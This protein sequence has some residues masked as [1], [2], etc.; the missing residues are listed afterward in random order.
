MN[1]YW[2]ACQFKYLIEDAPSANF[3]T[4]DVLWSYKIEGIPPNIPRTSYGFLS[5]LVWMSAMTSVASLGC[6]RKIFDFW[7]APSILCQNVD[8]GRIMEQVR[9]DCIPTSG[10]SDNSRVGQSIGLTDWTLTVVVDTPKARNP[11]AEMDMDDNHC[12]GKRIWHLTYR[13]SSHSNSPE[14]S[15]HW[16]RTG[17]SRRWGHRW[18]LG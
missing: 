2:F 8:W 3:K 17:Y 11:D 14:S 1:S 12:L 13:R 6:F 7:R 18:I 15:I 5:P 16:V 4:I 10:L 9:V